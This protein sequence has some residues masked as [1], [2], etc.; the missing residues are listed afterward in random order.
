MFWQ[1][2]HFVMFETTENAFLGEK[3][4]WSILHILSFIYHHNIGHTSTDPN[5]YFT[6]LNFTY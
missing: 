2:I 5:I 1:I 3:A 4:G 6:T